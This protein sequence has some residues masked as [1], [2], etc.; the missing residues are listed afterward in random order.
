MTD[1]LTLRMTDHQIRMATADLHR[2]ARRL[3]DDARRYADDLETGRTTDSGMTYRIAQ[4]ATE[5]LRQAARLDGM[6]TIGGL[7][8][9]EAR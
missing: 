2:D 5:L 6:R 3:A 8:E 7:I 1:S 4:S 9:G